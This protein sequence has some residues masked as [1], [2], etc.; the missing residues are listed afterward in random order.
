MMLRVGDVH[1]GEK[2][3]VK[4]DTADLD[5]DI[6]GIEMAINGKEKVGAGTHG[7]RGRKEKGSKRLILNV[8]KC[9]ALEELNIIAS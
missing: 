8:I 1:Q 2:G 9:Q 6:E 3:A 7:A 5:L 4:E